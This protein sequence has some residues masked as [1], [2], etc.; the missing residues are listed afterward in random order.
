MEYPSGEVKSNLV[1]AKSRVAPVKTVSIPRL[2]LCGAVLLAKLISRVQLSWLGRIDEVQCYTDS[3]VVLDWLARHASSWHTFVANR[4]SYIQTTVPEVGWQHIPGKLNP[5]DL[6]SRGL[7]A[8]DLVNSQLWWRGPDLS[9]IKEEKPSDDELADEA[10]EVAREACHL[11]T[12]HAGVVSELPDYLTRRSSTWPKLTRVI[13]YCLKYL[14]ILHERSQSETHGQQPH[15]LLAVHERQ[16]LMQVERVPWRQQVLTMEQLDK[17]ENHIHRV[18]QETAFHSELAALKRGHYVSK[19]SPLHQLYPFLDEENV[20]RANTR[21]QY[22]SLSWQQKHP[23]ILPKDRVTSLLIKHHHLDS[24]HGGLQDTLTLLRARYWIVHA[25]C[26]VKQVIHR[27]VKCVRHAGQ[28]QQQLMAALPAERCNPSPPFTHVGVDYAGYFMMKHASGRGHQA[29]KVWIAIFVCF[30]TRAVHLE[31]VDDNTTVSFIAAFKCF[32]SRR[33]LPSSLWMDQG[34]NLQGA[35]RELTRVYLALRRSPEWLNHLAMQKIEFLS[36]PPKGHH[37]GG[38][39]EAAVKA[40]KH[41]FKRI[42]GNFTPAWDEM[43]TIVCQIEACLNSRPVTPT[44]DMAY[45]E[46]ALTPGHFLIGRSLKAVP[47]HNYQEKRQTYLER[48]QIC[49]QIVQTFWTRWRNE[50]LCKYY[51]RYKWREIEE[52]VKI[53]DIVLL[54][55]KDFPPCDWGLAVVIGTKQGRDGLV[56]EVTVRT[57][58]SELTRPITKLVKLPVDQTES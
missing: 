32:V 40:F 52:S 31:I 13:A 17:A 53:G 33:G 54:I 30:A 16:Q 3:R 44:M 4:V 5:A 49:S 20:L 34:T 26:Q 22:A 19:G 42:V 25:R 47:Q 48:W 55:E 14:E 10:A 57:A 11:V 8:Q 35:C 15:P 43:R 37:Q 6:P 7:K 58:T 9:C 41:H 18:Q 29:H 46:P 45:E 39:W 1:Q 28:P 24:K 56:R 2:E 27:C 12:V 23:I 50:A 51:P 38:I 36:I 21:M